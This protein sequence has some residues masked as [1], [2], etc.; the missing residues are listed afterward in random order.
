MSF[1]SR[2]QGLA[3]MWICR[4]TKYSRI[5]NSHEDDVRKVSLWPNSATLR[6]RIILHPCA[7]THR[8][9]VAEDVV[10]AADV[11]PEFVF[12]QAL[13]RKR[14]RFAR[15]RTIPIV[16]GDLVGGVWRI[17]EQVILRVGCAG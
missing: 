5:S 4:P 14:R 16:A 3:E 12:V 11:R 13:G 8:I 7:G 2:I 6:L 9:A 17:L 10:H 1:T 15:I